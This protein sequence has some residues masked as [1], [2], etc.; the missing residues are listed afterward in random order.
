M[1]SVMAIVSREV[2]SGLAPA[3]VRLGVLL[4]LDRHASRQKA[5]Q[6]LTA[7]G[8]LFLVTVRPERDR[9]WLAGLI[10][11]P[12]FDGEAWR[13]APNQ[14]P[15]TDVTA[16]V[17][18]LRFH[19]GVGVPPAT[20]E[21]LGAKKIT[22]GMSLQAPRILTPE[23]EAVLRR[24]LRARARAQSRAATRREPDER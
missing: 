12:R 13:G 7:G 18:K 10:E 24:L 9:V 20:D 8:S 17:R 21:P 19:S 15:V 4:P 11:R 2:L 1:A 22:L 23:D 5:L 3:G 16:A 6:A 14:V